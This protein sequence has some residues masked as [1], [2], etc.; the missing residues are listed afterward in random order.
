MTVM[1][2]QHPMEAKY[3][4][5]RLSNMKIAAAVDVAGGMELLQVGK[6]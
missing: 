3:R 2:A 6:S 1:P 5:L 4:R